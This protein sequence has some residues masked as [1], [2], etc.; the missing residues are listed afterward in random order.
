MNYKTNAK[1]N[2][3]IFWHYEIFPKAFFPALRP[4]RKL[5]NVS[6][7]SASISLVFC[8]FDFQKAQSPPFT[9]LGIGRFFTMIMF[10]L[11]IWFVKF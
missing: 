4:F 5:L 2:G 1:Q 10:R 11:K 3:P 8:K 9:F 6:K 7:G